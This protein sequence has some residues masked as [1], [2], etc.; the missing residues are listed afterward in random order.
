MLWLD[1][2]PLKNIREFGRVSSDDGEENSVC[3][4]VECY[5]TLLEIIRENG[6]SIQKGYSDVV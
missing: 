1:Y 4:G 3:V 5:K 6:S 2:S